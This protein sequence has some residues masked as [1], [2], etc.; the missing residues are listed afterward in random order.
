MGFIDSLDVAN[1]GLQH[2]GVDK[3]AT[4]TEDSK[5]NNEMSFAYDKV[6]RAELRRN[7]WR[8]S[9]KT[10]VIRAIDTTTM[11]IVPALYNAATLYLSGAIVRDANGVYWISNTPNNINNNPGDTDV[12]D[13]YFGPLTVS[14]FDSTTTYSSGELVYEAGADP[15]SYQVYMSL[16]NANSDDPKVGTAY[17]PTAT[18]QTN[19]V[20]TSAGSNWR[21]L[22]P[23]NKGITPADGPAAFDIGATYSI[24]QTVTASD[25]FIY[26]SVGNGNIGHDPTTDAGVHWTNTHVA[27]G[28]SRTPTIITSSTKWRPVAATIQNPHFLYPVGSGPFSQSATRNVFWLPAG[29]L[30]EAPADPK[31]GSTSSLGAPGGLPYNDWKLDSSFIVTS[32]GGPIILRFVADITKVSDMDDMFCEGLACRLAVATCQP[33]TQSNQLIQTCA[34]EYNRFMGEARLVNAI[35]EGATEP[36]LD[37]YIECRA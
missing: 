14:I 10:A 12:W 7:V 16:Q 19:D 31:A 18:Y 29:F 4:P 34:S 15:G 2:L 13:M 26:S 28:W 27:N 33:L 36:P 20:V 3:I 11:L 37:D 35:E 25:N 6:R 32:D 23:F 17:D 24:A 30:R 21:S 22:I 9:V 1:R 5:A 8:F